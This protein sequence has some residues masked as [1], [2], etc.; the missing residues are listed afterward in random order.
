M[1]IDEE[2]SVYVSDYN[3]QRVMKW[4]KG[5]KDGIVVA[6]GQGQGDRLTQLHGP[7]GVI[8]DH[9]GH[10]YVADKLNNRIMR[11]SK[12]SKEGIIIVGG[13]GY[14]QQPN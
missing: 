10:V 5:A 8:V 1:F 2:Y 13:N 4:M 12:E 6:G 11:W 7:Q 9:F 3:G 14:G